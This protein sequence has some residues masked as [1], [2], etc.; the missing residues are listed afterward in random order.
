VLAPA[1]ILT[2]S[3]P[4][5]IRK[6]VPIYTHKVLVIALAGI[7]TE[8][9]GVATGGPVSTTGSSSHASTTKG[10]PIES[11]AESW[12]AYR[13]AP[14]CQQTGSTAG[15]SVQSTAASELSTLQNE[16]RTARL[17]E[18]ASQIQNVSAQLE[19]SKPAPQVV[20][21]P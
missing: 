20:N 5:F 16:R 2:A 21:N 13:N 1:T 4:I 17:D 6:Y 12:V 8:G 10:I 3:L 7:S 11:S 9:N 19:V 14:R 15:V 18:Q